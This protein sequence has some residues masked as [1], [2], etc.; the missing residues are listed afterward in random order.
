ML[1]YAKG[2]L[3]DFYAMFMLEMAKRNVEMLTT[4]TMRD[5]KAMARLTGFEPVYT[6]M[7]RVL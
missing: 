2:I 7:R 4:I 5:P 1:T 6:L 3:D